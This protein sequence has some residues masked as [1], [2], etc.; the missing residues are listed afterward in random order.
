MKI[1]KI[2]TNG[3]GENCYVA[4][5]GTDG[6]IVDPGGCADYIL[7]VAE[8]MNIHAILLTHGHFDH[9]MAAN[10]LREALGAKVYVSRLDAKMLTNPDLSLATDFGFTHDNITS[11][12]LMDDG[13][14]IAAGSMIFKAIATPGHS[15]GSM[16]FLC[17]NVLFSGDTLFKLSVG[18]HSPQDSDKITSSIKKLM[19]LPHDTHVFPGHN[20]NT[21]IGYERQNNPYAA[22]H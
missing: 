10:D 2:I 8:G 12:V 16:C 4:S 9:I 20:E 21:T 17:N 11:D 22:I 19:R 7:S 15:D 18:V 5:E 6:V 14:V 3:L 13:Y 1:K